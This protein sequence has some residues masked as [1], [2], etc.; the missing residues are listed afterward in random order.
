[1]KEGS[2]NPQGFQKTIRILGICLLVGILI[3]LP[4]KNTEGISV[5][6]KDDR[7]LLSYSSGDSFNINLKD[8]LSV[9]ETQVLDLGNHV[10]EKEIVTCPRLT[11][12]NILFD[13]QVNKACHLSGVLKANDSNSGEATIRA[14]RVG[15][16]S[17]VRAASGCA[18]RKLICV[19][20]PVGQDE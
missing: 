10:D 17:D 11:S 13:S 7:I 3:Y 5:A 18:G 12:K 8:I 15:A 9:T 2:S 4:T 20:R 6:V 14:I 16:S 1:M 19:R